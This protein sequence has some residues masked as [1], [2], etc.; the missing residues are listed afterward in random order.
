MGAICG[1]VLN[2]ALVAAMAIVKALT[3][4]IIKPSFG[5]T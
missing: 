3:F 5:A 1:S 2:S 4:A